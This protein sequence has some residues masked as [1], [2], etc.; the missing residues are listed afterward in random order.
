MHHHRHRGGGGGGGGSLTLPASLTPEQRAYWVIVLGPNCIHGARITSGVL[1]F[2]TAVMCMASLGVPWVVKPRPDGPYGTTNE[3][4]AAL[5]P[6]FKTCMRHFCTYAKNPD[7]CDRLGQG[8]ARLASMRGCPVTSH[9]HP[10]DA[11][12]RSLPPSRDTDEYCYTS[13]AW[14]TLPA[15]DTGRQSS[16]VALALVVIALAIDLLALLR[17]IRSGCEQRRPEADPFSVKW[18]RITL[19]YHGS[20]GMLLLSAAIQYAAVM[21]AYVD[22]VVPGTEVSSIV[23]FPVAVLRI[24]PA[25]CV[26]RKARFI[27]GSH[28]QPLSHFASYY[29][30]GF[31]LTAYRIRQ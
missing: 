22:D 15:D 16:T 28:C 7:E 19:L 17:Y 3:D 2:F 30:I 20:I 13:E 10:L 1:A 14:S 4:F 27:N 29:C 8:R 12:A 26:G 5:L 31:P 23:C 21:P 11:F 18:S 25:A 9:V 6:N 24:A